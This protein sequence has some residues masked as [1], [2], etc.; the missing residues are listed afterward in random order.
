MKKEMQIVKSQRLSNT[1]AKIMMLAAIEKA[2]ALGI[3]AT[4]AIVDAGGHIIL[5]ERM[6]GGRRARSRFGY[7]TCYRTFIGGRN[8]SMDCNGRWFSH[9]L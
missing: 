2:A 5:L 4:I 3:S 6:E 8:K 7:F 9:Y 1:G